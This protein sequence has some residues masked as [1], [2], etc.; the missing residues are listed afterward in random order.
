MFLNLERAGMPLNVAG[1]SVL[2]GEIPFQDFLDLV[3]SRLPLIPRY[4]K[5]VVAPPL[6]AALPAWEFDPKFD[7]RNHVREVTLKHGTNTELKALAARFWAPLWIGDIR[8]G[9]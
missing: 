2:E 5:R 9:I 3:E 7:I 8:S 1:V 6:N 4:L